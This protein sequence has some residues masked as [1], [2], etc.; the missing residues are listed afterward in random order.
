[1]K[2]AA[3][4]TLYEGEKAVVERIVDLRRRM[5][6]GV[7]EPSSLQ[8]ELTAQLGNL[9]KTHP[10]DRM[11]YAHV[12]EQAVASVISDWTGIPAGRMVADELEAILTLSDTL[13]ARVIGQDH[14]LTMIARRIE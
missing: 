9:G 7:E 13:R 10:D 5:A 4:E 8:G 12:D 14:G 11:I 3:A 1:A 6:E 2:L